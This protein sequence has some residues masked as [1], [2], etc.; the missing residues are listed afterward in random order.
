MS[1]NEQPKPIICPQCGQS[2]A[3]GR[4]TCWNCKGSLVR[5]AEP[6]RKKSS[7]TCWIVG[8]VVSLFLVVI[9]LVIGVAGYFFARPSYG[10]GMSQQM[11]E[12]EIMKS[13]PQEQQNK[14]NEEIEKAIK[15]SIMEEKK[16]KSGQVIDPKTI[17]ISP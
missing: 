4:E 15:K 1:D 2:N 16:K 8:C 11:M 5:S 7:T 17:K 13:I 6:P 9:L 3:Q 12:E 14:M 10:P